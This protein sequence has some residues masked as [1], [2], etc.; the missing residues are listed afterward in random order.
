[1][2]QEALTNVVRHAGPVRATIT[3]RREPRSVVLRVVNAP[4]RR[5]ATT[6]GSGLGLEGMA[7][8]TGMFGGQLA[9]GATP[10]GGFEVEARFP[11]DDH[12]ALLRAVP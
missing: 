1:V 4:G 11:I 8:R 7:Q 6:A 3:L 5:T 12:P 10:D 9:A 2:A